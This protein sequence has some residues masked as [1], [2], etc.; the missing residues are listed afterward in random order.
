M[1]IKSHNNLMNFYNN[2][3]FHLELDFICFIRTDNRKIEKK[4]KKIIRNLLHQKQ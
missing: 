2:F 3:F 1:Q 4:K